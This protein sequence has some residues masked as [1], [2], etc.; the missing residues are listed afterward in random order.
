MENPPPIWVRATHKPAELLLDTGLRRSVGF[1]RVPFARENL[2]PGTDVKNGMI[3]MK[4][5]LAQP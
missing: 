5:I 3:T 2:D 4:M 1:R